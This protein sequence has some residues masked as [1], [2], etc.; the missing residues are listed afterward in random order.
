MG[1]S[2][3]QLVRADAARRKK[4]EEE[5][6]KEAAERRAAGLQKLDELKNRR[7]SQIEHLSMMEVRGKSSQKMFAAQWSTSR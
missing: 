5:E 7:S 3:Q 6:K 2:V 1:T 4:R